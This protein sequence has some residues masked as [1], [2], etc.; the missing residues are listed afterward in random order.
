MEETKTVNMEHFINHFSN[1]K[2][3]PQD[4]ESLKEKIFKKSDKY[5]IT[6]DNDWIDI[7]D[8]NSGDEVFSFISNRSL[9]VSPKIDEVEKYLNENGINYAEKTLGHL[10]GEYTKL[11]YIYFSKDSVSKFQTFME[12][13]KAFLYSH[14]VTEVLPKNRETIREL[15]K[16]I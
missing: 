14:M 12:N 1:S 8:L 9:V 13:D 10:S 4:F 6:F 16:L 15:D 3:L 11:L 2:K 5:R 7:F